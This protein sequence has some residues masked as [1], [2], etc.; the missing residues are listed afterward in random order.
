MASNKKL[1][2][3]LN[4]IKQITGLNAALFQ[5]GGVLTVSTAAVPDTLRLQV[6]FFAE[7]EESVRTCAGWQLFRVE[8]EEELLYI[9]TLE[10]GSGENEILGRMAAL[11]VRNLLEGEREQMDRSHFIQ[12]VLL[13]NLPF[14]DMMNKARRLHIDQRPRAVYAID[15][16]G[17]ESDMILELLKNLSDMRAGDFVTAIDEQRIVLVRDLSRCKENE[18]EGKMEE[19]ARLLHDN[20]AAEAYV[21][22]RIAYGNPTEQLEKLAEAYRQACMALEVARVFSP[23]QYTISYGRLGLGRLIH[24]LPPELCRMY[25]QEVFGDKLPDILEDEEAMSTISRFFENNLNI[26]ETARQLYVHRNTLVY[27][28]ERIQKAIGLDIRNFEDAITFRM[29]MMVLSHLKDIE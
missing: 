8:S 4:E 16:A 18:L 26:S 7:T 27:R 1:Q 9:L 28:M 19:Y 11:Q 17:R 13:G 23:E 10:N 3:T 12:N 22:C 5:P 25:I 21:R 14:M 24:Q 20:L 2:N 15:I 29:A 6:P